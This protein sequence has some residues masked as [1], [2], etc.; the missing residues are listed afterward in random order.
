MK[1]RI[2][3]EQPHVIEKDSGVYTFNL[4]EFSKVLIA[5]IFKERELES[6]KVNLIKKAEFNLMDFFKLLDWRCQGMLSPSDIL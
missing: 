6:L 1:H 2:Y 3:E 4:H 5:Y